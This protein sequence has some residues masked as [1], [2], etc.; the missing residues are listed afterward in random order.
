MS[1]E[2]IEHLDS[3]LVALE[4][5]GWT[6]NRIHLTTADI[7]RL[8]LQVLAELGVWVKP[9][10]ISSYR[11]VPIRPGRTSSIS[12]VRDGEQKRQPFG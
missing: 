7:E 10:G 1:E 3:A 5:S 6:A 9:E 8:R 12:A 2:I 11:S 4:T